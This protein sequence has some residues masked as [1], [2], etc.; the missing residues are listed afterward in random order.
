LELAHLEAVPAVEPESDV[1]VEP[2]VALGV[3]A[4]DPVEVARTL[5]LQH[6]LR[7]AELVVMVAAVAGIAV[8]VEQVAV[9]PVAV[10]LDEAFK[11]DLRATEGAD[12]YRS[13][14][15]GCDEGDQQGR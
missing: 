15:S 11:A 2:L 13:L 4:D 8:Q 7:A 12:G 5:A 3:V 1:D 14:C 6:Q 9:V 10:G